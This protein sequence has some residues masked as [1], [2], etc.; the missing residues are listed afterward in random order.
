[1]PAGVHR[2]SVIVAVSPVSGS[3]GIQGPIQREASRVLLGQAVIRV[4]S[5]VDT[6]IPVRTEE[7]RQSGCAGGHRIPGMYRTVAMGR[8]KSVSGNPEL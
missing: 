5:G 6:V 3:I 8:H 1:M 4:E 7:S 2:G